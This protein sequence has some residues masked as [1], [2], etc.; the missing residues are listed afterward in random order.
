MLTAGTAFSRDRL[1]R[2]L[3]TTMRLTL[4]LLWTFPLYFVLVA[5]HGLFLLCPILLLFTFAALFGAKYLRSDTPQASA[6]VTA[7]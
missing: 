5:I 3:R 4:M 1:P 2:F 7:G 6:L